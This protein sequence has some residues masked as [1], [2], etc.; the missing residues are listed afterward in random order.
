MTQE[1]QAVDTTVVQ[2]RSVL[3]FMYALGYTLDATGRF[4]TE[5]KNMSGN[6]YLK[7]NTA[8]A[9]H[10]LPNS[11]W[12]PVTDKYGITMMFPSCVG[13]Q[14]GFNP[15]GVT[16]AVASKLV[17]KAKISVTRK[18]GIVTQDVMVKPL[19]QTVL[20]LVEQQ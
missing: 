15:L 19:N 8:V 4:V 12:K 17:D 14:S 18:G 11:E 13:L 16:L 6:R 5:S 3:N 1:F 7:A 20:D 9:M 10:N 2:V